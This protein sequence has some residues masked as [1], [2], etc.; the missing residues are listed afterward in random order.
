[1]IGVGGTVQPCQ[2]E[3]L[4]YLVDTL[5]NFKEIWGKPACN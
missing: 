4:S 3:T 2:V 1:M 5:P